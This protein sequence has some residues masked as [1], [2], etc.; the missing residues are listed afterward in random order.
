[1]EM[2]LRQAGLIVQ[3]RMAIEVRFR[4]R[5]IGEFRGDLV[6]EGVLLLELKAVRAP[7]PA[8]EAQVLNDLRAAHLEAG[9]LLNF[10][11]K[12]EVKRSAFDNTRK[13]A[14]PFRPSLD[15]QAPSG[16]ISSAFICG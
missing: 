7:E 13:A 10:G 6:V 5:T 2:V 8:R 1:M 11:P 16:S 12:P 14:R 3:R 4:G 9:L 15:F